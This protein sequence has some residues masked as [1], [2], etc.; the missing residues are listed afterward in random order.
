MHIASGGNCALRQLSRQTFLNCGASKGYGHGCD[1]GDVYDVYGYMKEHGLPDDSCQAYTAADGK[2][3]AMG[4]CMNCMEGDGASRCWPVRHYVNYK[5]QGYNK[6][7]VHESEREAAV[8][9]ELMTRGPVA[10]GMFTDD[11]FDYEYAGGVWNLENSNG[12]NNHDVE[13]VG[14]GESQGV[15]YWTVRNS[16]GTFWGEEGFFRIKRGLKKGLVDGDCWFAVPEKN[17]SARDSEIGSM[18][19]IVQKSPRTSTFVHD[20]L[21]SRT[22]LYSTVEVALLASTAALCGGIVATCVQQKRRRWEYGTI[23]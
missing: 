3:D 23:A 10:C 2:C 17:E 7:S 5:I 14:W 1:G 20:I 22:G 9:S 13:L 19:G 6:I 18:F 21:P 11:R 16:W 12:T 15:P 4:M 8:M